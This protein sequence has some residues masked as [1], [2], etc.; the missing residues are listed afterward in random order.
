LIDNYK[1]R[2]DP[3][4]TVR[5]FRPVLKELKIRQKTDH[6]PVFLASHDQLA[7][8]NLDE[9]SIQFGV[10]DINADGLFFAK[11]TKGRLLRIFI[12][13][14]KRLY[15]GEDKSM[16]ELLKI[17]G[18]HEFVHSLALIF[19]AAISKRE[20]MPSTLIQRLNK[21]IM[22]M[23][24]Q[25]LLDLYNALS[26]KPEYKQKDY[27]DSHFRL[28]YEGQTCD[29]EVLFLYFLFS[30]DLFEEYFDEAKQNEFN[31]LYTTGRK[32]DA[33][34]LM[35]DTLTTAADDKDVPY[36]TA[37]NQL[38]EWANVYFKRPN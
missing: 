6:L 13:L 33:T 1:Y 30:R 8:L 11:Y 19:V 28:G 4:E 27:T 10:G 16:K 2:I 7:F 14:N 25:N 17:A 20:D 38:F 24:D 36:N 37:K 32:D 34:R 22:D 9:C 29:Y 12:I 21:K 23:W 26:G 3:R 5:L 31:V 35:L 18:V 15:D